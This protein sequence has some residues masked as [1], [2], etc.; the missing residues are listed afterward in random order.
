MMIYCCNRIG[1]HH[2]VSEDAMLAG[3]TVYSAGLYTVDMPEHGWIAVADGVGGNRGGA[4]ASRF[5]LDRLCQCQGETVSDALLQINRDLIAQGKASNQ[6]DMA[7]TLTGIYLQNGSRT[8]FHIGNTR[9]YALQGHY[10]KQLTTDH[11]TYQWLRATGRMAEAEA[12]N[13]N[14]MIACLGGGSERL[15]SRFTVQ[16]ITAYRYMLLTS[17]GIHDYV[18]LDTLEAIVNEAIPEAQKCQ[19]IMET[20]IE[21]GSE[22]DLSIVIAAFS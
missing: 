8:L 1:K 4:E 19:K 9:A 14:E 10:L 20:A 13:Q 7:T 22:D 16:K 2:A 18:D 21:N 15:F 17:D 11:T 3:N 5:V 12:C 6:P